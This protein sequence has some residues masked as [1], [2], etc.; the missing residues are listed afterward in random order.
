MRKTTISRVW[1][2]GLV[3]IAGGAVAII[4]GTILMLAY[5]GTWGGVSG[6]EFQPALDAFFFWMVGL[7]SI[8]GL[9]VLAGCIAQVVA[10]IGALVNAY[11]LAE[12]TWFVVLLVAGAIGVLVLPVPGFVAMLVYVLAG[13]DSMAQA[14][15]ETAAV[16]PP[17]RLAPAS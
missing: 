4:V 7:I 14:G 3:G 5:A 10:W 1:L 17:A 9:I 2:G 11:A 6:D 12:K 15:R 8:G 16:T 13:P